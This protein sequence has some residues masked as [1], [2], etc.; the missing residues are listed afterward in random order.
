MFGKED[1]STIKEKMKKVVARMLRD[2]GKEGK[3]KDI[4]DEVLMS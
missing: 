3:D 2:Q 4:K 1:I